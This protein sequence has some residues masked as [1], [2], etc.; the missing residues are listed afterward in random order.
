MA[1]LKDNGYVILCRAAGSHGAAD[2]IALKQSELLFIQCKTSGKDSTAKRAELLRLA[3]WAD[4]I[5]LQSSYKPLGPK[6]GRVIIYEQISPAALIP[7]NPDHA[8][9]TTL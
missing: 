2:V 3:Q 9:E 8:M 1:N 5:P 7:W 6:G 4:A